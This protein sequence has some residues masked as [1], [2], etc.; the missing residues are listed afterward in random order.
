M[1][2]AIITGLP[3]DIKLKNGY[4]LRLAEPNELNFLVLHIHGTV[5]NSTKDETYSLRWIETRR[6]PYHPSFGPKWIGTYFWQAN[7]L[8]MEIYQKGVLDVHG[9]LLFC[10]G[11]FSCALSTSNLFYQK[12][13]EMIAA[14]SKCDKSSPA[15]KSLK[16]NFQLRQLRGSDAD[17]TITCEDTSIPVHSLVMKTFW[18]YF[19]SLSETKCVEMTENRLKLDYPAAWIEKLVSYLYGEKLLLSFDEL[20]GLMVLGDLY[21]L[22]ALSEMASL[23]LLGV[24]ESSVTLEEVIT[25]WQKASQVNKP[26]VKKHLAKII[27]TKHKE[28][29]TI[30]TEGL[31]AKYDTFETREALELFFDSLGL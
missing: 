26:L 3:L 22:P 6:P 19:K 4:T 11:D 2:V 25:G 28:D 13:S 5:G 30:D 18:P 31:L 23:E 7:T 16:G 14:E 20:T 29:K 1:P 27:V 24:S 9:F 10:E 17:F 21:Q 15:K 8:H 12:K